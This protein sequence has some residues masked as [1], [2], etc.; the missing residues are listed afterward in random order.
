MDF[1]TGDDPCVV[2]DEYLGREGL[3][4]VI[5]E[6]GNESDNNLSCRTSRID[7]FNDLFLNEFIRSSI[8]VHN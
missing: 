5:L 7:A 1:A 6:E 3:E 8:H 4:E 2:L